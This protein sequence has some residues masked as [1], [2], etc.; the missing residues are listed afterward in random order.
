MKY[1][2]YIF[3]MLMMIGCETGQVI[4]NAKPK[5]ID[6]RCRRCGKRKKFQ[7][8]RIENRGG[9][10][11]VNFLWIP[12]SHNLEIEDGF[13]FMEM[14]QRNRDQIHKKFR[15]ESFVRAS[16]ILDPSKGGES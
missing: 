16:E 14:A 12:G 9:L 7:P 3:I 15:A 5:T 2:T 10:R 1:F 8:N 11:S 13:E 6:S 4:N